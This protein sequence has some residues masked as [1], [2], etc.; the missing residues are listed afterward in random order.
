M[1]RGLRQQWWLEVAAQGIRDKEV[2]WHYLLTLLTSGAEGTTKVLAKC[3]VATWRWNI[4]VQ[5]KGVCPP[6]PMVLNIG[7]FLTNQEMEG[8]LGEPHWFVAYSC[9]LQRVGETAHRRKWNVQQESLE[10]KASL[11]VYAFWCKTSVDLMMASIKHCWE[12]TPS[13]LHHQRDNGPTTHIISYLDELAVHPPT[14]EAWDELVWPSTAVTLRVPTEA[15]FYGYCQGQVVDLGPI[16]PA[17]Q[18]CVTNK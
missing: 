11:L 12:P 8:G 14:S 2:P 15:E 1:K 6:T 5:G 9:M 10:I 16:M 13:T 7:Q 4:K 3:Q 18:F 17:V